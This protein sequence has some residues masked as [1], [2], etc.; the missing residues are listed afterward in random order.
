MNGESKTE[1]REKTQVRSDNAA[2]ELDILGTFWVHLEDFLTIL[3]HLDP[4]M[5]VTASID[6]S[7]E[8]LGCVIYCF[9]VKFTNEKELVTDG[10]TDGRTHPHIEMR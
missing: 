5:S 8:T 10:R 7:N 3:K 4:L 9:L 1:K 6:G 2:S